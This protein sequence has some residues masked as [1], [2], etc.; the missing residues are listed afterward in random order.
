MLLSQSAGRTNG[1]DPDDRLDPILFGA[2]RVARDWTDVAAHWVWLAGRPS[3]SLGPLWWRA[4]SGQS[5]Q[6]ESSA[7]GNCFISA[8]GRPAYSG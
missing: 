4:A 6:S 3:G 5:E 2:D 8:G 1:L 7:G